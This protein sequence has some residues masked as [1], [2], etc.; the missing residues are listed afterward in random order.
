MADE[1]RINVSMQVENGEFRHAFKP[2]QITVDQ[3]DM[4]RG[5]YVQVITDTAAT[6]D[7]GGT[8]VT[9]GWLMMQNLDKLNYITWGPDNTGLRDMGRLL[10]GEFAIFRLAPSPVVLKAAAPNG[11]CRLDVRLFED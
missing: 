1:I 4:G 3:S 11:T 9:Y 2:G 10:P 7:F 5:G 6:I 8:L